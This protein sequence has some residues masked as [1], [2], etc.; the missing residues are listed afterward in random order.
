M[1]EQ[2]KPLRL[3]GG[4]AE[5]IQVIAAILQDAIVSTG[6]ISFDAA[7]KKFLMAAS[8]FCWERAQGDGAAACERIN[9]AVHVEGVRAVKTLQI[10]MNDRSKMLDL[11]TIMAEPGALVLVFAGG[12]RLKLD[13]EGLAVRLEDFG[14]P[15]PVNRAPC[16]EQQSSAEQD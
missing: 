9:C 7:G 14:Q 16:H 8:R 15:W 2:F 10:D 3:Q 11:L 13:I 5:D 12:P 4:D 6:D 1:T